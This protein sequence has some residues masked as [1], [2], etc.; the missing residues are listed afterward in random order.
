MQKVVIIDYGSGNLRSA[1]KAFERMNSELGLNFTIEVSSETDIV[2]RADRVVLPGVG[3]FPDCYTGVAKQEGLLEALN[4]IVITKAR[5][6]LGICVGMQLMASRGYENGETIGFNW[7]EG[8]VIAIKKSNAQV[9]I[10]HMGWNE[11]DIMVK[12]HLVIENLCNIAQKPHVY[13][14]HSFH[15]VP[16]K[17]DHIL[18]VT[19]YGQRV[20]A[21]VGKD[22]MI[23]T[24]FHPEKSQKTGLQLIANFLQWSP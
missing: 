18:A 11:L 22:N 1:A 21:M 19:E 12:D 14:V 10:P 7:I 4:E 20:T 3:S 15:M 5:P 13:F 23:G 8:D 24:Q 16:K 6:F 17:S 2:M 9:K